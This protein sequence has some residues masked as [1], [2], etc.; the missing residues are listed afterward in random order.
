M[1]SSAPN[2]NDIPASFQ[3][4]YETGF[5]TIYFNEELSTILT[6]WNANSEHITDDDYR[7]DAEATMDLIR[8]SD[9]HH[10]IS[11]HRE[12]KFNISPDLQKWYAELIAHVLGNSSFK[13]CAVVITTDLN[14]LSALEEIKSNIENSEEENTIAYKFFNS[15]KDAEKWINSKI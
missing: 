2:D 6:I 8:D 9:A 15:M 13:K 12:N 3:V 10:M 4:I 11:D 5:K 7:N 1:V 14:L